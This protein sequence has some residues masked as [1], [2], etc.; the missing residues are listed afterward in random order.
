MSVNVMYAKQA[1]LT[2]AHRK[3]CFCNSDQHLLSTASHLLFSFTSCSALRLRPS[4][5][6]I[7][8]IPQLRGSSGK[9]HPTTHLQIPSSRLATDL[10]VLLHRKVPLSARGSSS[11]QNPRSGIQASSDCSQPNTSA[12]TPRSCPSVAEPSRAG[13]AFS[14]VQAS[15]RCAVHTCTSPATHSALINCFALEEWSELAL[16]SQNDTHT[17]TTRG[18]RPF[19]NITSTRGI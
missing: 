9:A 12:A 16:L 8:D 5:S 19:P 11:H 7:K 14:S 3:P 1:T 10:T 4:I 18:L 6:S 17:T 13:P 2:R 15:A